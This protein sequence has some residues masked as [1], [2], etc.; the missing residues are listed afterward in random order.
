MKVIG[1]I[2]NSTYICEVSHTELE[3][4]F[5]KYYNK[6]D[7][8]RVG[9]TIDLARGYDFKHEIDDA[10]KDTKHF[11]EKN[12][13]IIEAILN[14]FSVAGLKAETSKQSEEVCQ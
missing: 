11:I 12:K 1:K 3:Q 10:L 8:L 2:D 6:M 13:K 5:D 14:G 7:K 4:Y 9:E